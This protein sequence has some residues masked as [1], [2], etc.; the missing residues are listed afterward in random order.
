MSYNELRTE[1]NVRLISFVVLLGLFINSCYNLSG[2]KSSSNILEKSQFLENS[3]LPIILTWDYNIYV[4]G[5]EEIKAFVASARESNI[6]QINLR[7]NNKG[8]M[9]TRIEHG[10]IYTERLDAFGKDFD[11]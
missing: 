9:N 11:P 5:P 8:V 3:D 4:M 1:V 10:R 7:V 6:S 2:L